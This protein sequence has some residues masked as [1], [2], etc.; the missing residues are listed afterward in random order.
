MKFGSGKLNLILRAKK[1]K[2]KAIAV[3]GREGS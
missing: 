3:R 1:K 2:G